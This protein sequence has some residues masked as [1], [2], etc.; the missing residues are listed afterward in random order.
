MPGGCHVW[1]K[2]RKIPVID[3]VENMTISYPD[4][5]AGSPGINIIFLKR[6]ANLAEEFDIPFQ[7]NSLVQS[8]QEGGDKGI[9]TLMGEDEPVK[10]FRILPV[11][12]KEHRHEK[13]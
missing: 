1:V 3:L 6:Q 2:Q 5:V 9:P 11:C 10:A 4:S 7:A 12:S 13:C 8:I